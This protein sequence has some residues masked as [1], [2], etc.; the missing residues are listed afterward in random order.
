MSLLVSF[1]PGEILS[2]GDVRF[3]LN[4]HPPQIVLTDGSVQALTDTAISPVPDVMVALFR[5]ILEAR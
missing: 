3:R 4:A 2:I 5:P 1:R